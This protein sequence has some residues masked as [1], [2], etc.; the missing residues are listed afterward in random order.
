MSPTAL[1]AKSASPSWFSK[2]YRVP[3]FGGDNY[4]TKTHFFSYMLWGNT[5]FRVTKMIPGVN[6]VGSGVGFM[7]RGYELNLASMYLPEITEDRDERHDHGWQRF[8]KGADAFI[9]LITL[10]KESEHLTEPYSE[11][12]ERAFEDA[13]AELRRAL[14]RRFAPIHAPLIVL[15]CVDDLPTL[16]PSAVAERLELNQIAN[17][18]V[19][20]TLKN[21][22]LVD[23]YFALDWLTNHFESTS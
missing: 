7:V 12:L 20:R 10:P 17:H 23:M 16:S 5:P 15:V 2:V 8:F 21:N 3:V 6:G 18:F 13:K 4:S 1:H 19:V 22:N 11:A 9:Y 14:D